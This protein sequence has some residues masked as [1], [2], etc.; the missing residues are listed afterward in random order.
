MATYDV[1]IVGAGFSGLYQL[2]ALRER[3]YAVHLVEANAGP[4]GVWEAN[5]YPGVRVDS[6]VPNYEYSIEAVWRDWVW[7]ERFPGG[8]E[9]RRY[10]RHVEDCLD[11]AR[12]ISYDTRVTGARFDGDEAAWTMEADSG[13][14]LTARHLILCTGFATTPYVPDL[15]GLERFDVHA[16]GF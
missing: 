8:E 11:L 4:G 16:P 15:P 1:V 12:H 14:P 7:S 5:R 9:I 2:Y 13:R 10:F 3:G 6:H